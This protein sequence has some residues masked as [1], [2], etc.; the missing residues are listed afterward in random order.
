MAPDAEIGSGG[1]NPGADRT[2]VGAQVIPRSEGLAGF[3]FVRC[4][5]AGPCWRPRRAESSPCAGTG[6]GGH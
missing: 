6:C 2:L 4:A 1:A 3:G 5:V